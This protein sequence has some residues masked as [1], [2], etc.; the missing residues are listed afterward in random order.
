[1]KAAGSQQLKV[2][3]TR[4]ALYAIRFLRLAACCLLLTVLLLAS[5]GKKGPPTLKSYEKP[6]PPANLKALHIENKILLQWSHARKESLKGFNV[7]K[8]SGSDFQKIAFVGKEENSY[9]DTD[10]KEDVTYK[11]KI[12]AQ[13]LKS[14]TSDDSNAVTMKPMAVPA[15]PVN[16]SFSVGNNSI[17]LSWEGVNRDIHYNIYK[18]FEKGKY[19]ME[20]LNA[21]P[22]K[23]GSYSD[24]LETAN[25]VYYSVR[26]ALNTEERHE[27]PASNEIEVN[28]ADFM[29]SMPEGLQAVPADD[30]VILS[31]KENPETWVVKYR[32]Y[33]KTSQKEEFEVAGESKTPAFT[34]SEMIGKRHIYRVT[35][36][37][38]SKESEPSKEVAVQF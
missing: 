11:Y 9:A 23:T 5:C 30:K 1:M 20:P 8:S 25:P 26:A 4:C 7:L 13:S 35:A 28:H 29:P 12:A 22:E 37:G 3:T 16:L 2:E 27:G 19:G 10:F 15:A 36:V 21:E 34:D 38:P 6:D 33:R 14:V 32:I 31:W 17:L 24:T 18:S